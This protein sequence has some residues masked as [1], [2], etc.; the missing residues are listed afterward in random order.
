MNQ[1]PPAILLSNGSYRD[2]VPVVSPGGFSNVVASF[3][4]PANTTAYTIGDRVANSATAAT[5]LELASVVA[6]AGDTLSIDRIRLSKTSAVLT[7]A[8][9]RVYLF[10]SLPVVTPNDNGVLDTA[11][12][13][14]IA[15]I[16][17]L[18]G[19]FDVTM[20]YAGTVGAIGQGI[21]AVGGA[22][23]TDTGAGTSLY[24]VFE[25][26]AAY[27]PASGETFALT[28]EISQ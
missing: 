16:T 1:L 14:A 3:A 17:N 7:D 22:I 26:L 28:L 21:P 10:R 25:A 12:A 11:G 19:S 15:N 24:A 5:V 6:A 23:V 13:L 9:F 18:V 2:T 20:N 27:V 8:Q 4:R